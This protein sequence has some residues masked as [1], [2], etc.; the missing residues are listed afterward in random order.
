MPEGDSRPGPWSQEF[1]FLRMGADLPTNVPGAGADPAE[2]V[3]PGIKILF[4]MPSQIIELGLF[5]SRKDDGE[6]LACRF[7]RLVG[8]LLG[9]VSDIAIESEGL[10]TSDFRTQEQ[11]YQAQLEH[12]SNSHDLENT[13]EKCLALCQKY[14]RRAQGYLLERETEIREVVGVLK[15]AVSAFTSDADAFNQRLADSSVRFKRLNEI[16][17]LR[18]LKRQI[19]QEV[20]E[21]TRM[22]VEKR[23]QDEAH[24][25]KMSRRFDLLQ[26]KLRQTKQEVL[27]DPLTQ[28]GNRRSVDHAMKRASQESLEPFILAVIDLDDFKRVND[29]HGHQ[30]GDQALMCV[31]KWL[32]SHIRSGDFLG[33]F[34][35][36]EFV[37]LFTNTT[38]P[39]AEMRFLQLLSF[40]AGSE[41]E[42]REGGTVCRLRLTVSC[43]LAQSI[44][45]EEPEDLLRRADK[46]LYEAKRRG[47]N[48]LVT[49]RKPD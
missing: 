39:Q 48:C 22:V 31:A 34:G 30:A 8:R 16:D 27:M 36:D 12:V 14:F 37:I 6:N 49:W 43:G 5:K 4:H 24:Y 20:T 32:N 40:V 3:H 13:V 25:A 15:N 33:R 35:G 28:V 38:L 9:L 18:E 23:K 17:D 41:F 21:L 7:G 1:D 29:L 2:A 10:K 19:A 26:Q 46:A 11:R 47:N 42:V 45:G 44:P